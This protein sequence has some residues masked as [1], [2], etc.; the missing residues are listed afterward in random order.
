MLEQYWKIGHS[1][2]GEFDNT[3]TGKILARIQYILLPP[4]RKV[5]AQVG[6]KILVGS[7]NGAYEVAFKDFYNGR[8]IVD[9]DENI[10]RK[11]EVLELLYKSFSRKDFP[12]IS[13]NQKLR[14]KLLEYNLRENVFRDLN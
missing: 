7:F 13:Q 6:E 1:Y 9:K 5:A 2:Y 8:G 12:S 10:E 3:L 11:I 14:L 4:C